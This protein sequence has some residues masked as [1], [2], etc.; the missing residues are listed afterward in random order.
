MGDYYSVRVWQL[1]PGASAAE[2]EA[3]T[4]SGILEMQRWIPGVKH[5]SLIRLA[6]ESTR[7][8]L[9]TT[10]VNAEAYKRWRQVEEEGPD[11]W[12]RYASVLMHWE[13]LSALVE[14]Y[15]GEAVVDASVEEGPNN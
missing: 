2:V 7:Y 13:Q 11:Y 8:L 15:V 14:E 1:K 9:I 6:G 3:L 5:L 10:F 12:E 4:A